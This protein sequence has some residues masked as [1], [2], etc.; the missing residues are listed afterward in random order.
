LTPAAATRTSTSSS[1]IAG[2]G[3]RSG[4]STSGPPG[5]RIAI[6]VISAGKAGIGKFLR[7]GGPRFFRRRREM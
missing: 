3:R 1:A 6:T 5:A 7:H 4:T 2:S